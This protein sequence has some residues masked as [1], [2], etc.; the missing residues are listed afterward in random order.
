MSHGQI[1]GSAKN[2]EEKAFEDP[3]GKEAGKDREEKKQG[4]VL[5]LGEGSNRA[6]TGSRRVIRA[7]AVSQCRLRWMQLSSSSWTTRIDGFDAVQ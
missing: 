1:T 3:E 5:T 2:R 6:L 4:Q 7:A